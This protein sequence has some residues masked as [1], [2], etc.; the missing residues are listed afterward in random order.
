ML[1]MF[2][3][4]VG[5]ALGGPVE[6]K[7]RDKFEPVTDVEWY[8]LAAYLY[9]YFLTNE[10]PPKYIIYQCPPWNKKIFYR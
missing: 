8:S 4:I 2:G 1:W 7:V 10:Q 3:G 6:F 5:D 9:P